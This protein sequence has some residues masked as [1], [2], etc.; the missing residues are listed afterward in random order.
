MQGRHSG[1]TAGSLPGGDAVRVVSFEEAYSGD[2]V[3]DPAGQVAAYTAV[4]EEALAG[5]YTGL[6]VVADVTALVRTDE[7]RDA[8]AR[9][10]YIIGR[11]MRLAPMRA[12]CA[13]DRGELGERAVAE[14]AC[15]HE[16]SH[17]AGVTFQLHPGVTSAEAMLDGEL[18][19]SAEELFGTAL[20]RT[21]L[22]R[23][24]GD[25]V[26]D[27]AGLRFIDHR[28]LLALEKYAA[29]RRTTAVLRT[30][31]G[32]VARLAGLLELAHVRVEGAR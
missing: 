10:E 23:A 7:Q 21:D 19:M 24:G 13:Y 18:D 31:T 26:V 2:G 8:F 12:V 32:A 1:V 5:G 9:Y 30:P 22:D 6:R 29:S 15:L 11:Y 27:G 14:L 4:T 3:V 20:E 28:A 16:S 25:V 17:D